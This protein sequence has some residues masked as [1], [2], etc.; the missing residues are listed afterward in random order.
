MIIKN[1]L[2]MSLVNVYKAVITFILNISI[3]YFVLPIEYGLV[4]FSLPFITFVAM[5][6]DLGLASALVRQETL[7]KKDA[8]AAFSLMLAIGIAGAALILLSG[9]IMEGD[10]KLPGIFGVMAGLSVSVVL[11]I[12]AIT[13]RALL[14]RTLRYQS[15][16]AI[17]AISVTVSGTT[18]MILA[19]AGWGVWA[20]V[21]YYILT[22]FLR[23]L[24]F[25][26]LC[27]L[28]LAVNFEWKRVVPMLSIG[29]W[30]L[31]SNLLNFAARR[32]DV[33]LIG[34]VLG[35]A[36]VGL[37][38]FAYQFMLV[39]LM[40]L[41][42]PASSVLMATLSRLDRASMGRQNVII[43]GLITVSS[44]VT[45]PSMLYVSFASD[46]LI[47][48]L[49]AK[50]W[51]G[52]SPLVAIL[53]P[54]GAVQSVAVYNGAVLLANGFARRQFV[55]GAVNTLLLL[56]T[57]FVTVRY[58]LN[59][60][61]LAYAIIAIPLSVW[62]TWIT[63]KTGKVSL[64]QFLSAVAPASVGTGLG[65][66]CVYATTGFAIDSVSGWALTTAVYGGAVLFVYGCMFTQLRASLLFLAKPIN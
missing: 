28:E 27:R 53:A 21:F 25:M 26:G 23:A 11:S 50:N 37:Y 57:F 22:Q 30:V 5:I 47:T 24:L 51:H 3:A 31:A 2:S 13:P 62:M 43:A 19:S 15:V 65:L 49:L 16:A 4:T 64:R 42:W 33:I 34:S 56:L 14:E 58:G 32:A 35:A 46:F 7:S 10:Q 20:F 48:S 41:G 66:L 54:V 36:A 44:A 52:V 63:C 29:G 38:G 8:G 45:F 59:F 61:V 1:I 9:Y 6:T 18:A 55:V 17:E 39:P 40:V 60:M 12:I